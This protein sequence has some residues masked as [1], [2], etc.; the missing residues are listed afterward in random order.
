VSAAEQCRLTTNSPAAS[1]HKGAVSN[2]FAWHEIKGGVFFGR[3]PFSGDI[4]LCCNI[5]NGWGQAFSFIRMPDKRPSTGD[6]P[7]AVC[8]DTTRASNPWLQSANPTQQEGNRRSLGVSIQVAYVTWIGPLRNCMFCFEE[9]WSKRTAP[10]YL[11]PGLMAASVW[12]PPPIRT[13]VTDWMSRSNPLT[14]PVVKVWSNPNGFPMAR[15]RCP[16]R[17]RL[18]SPNCRGRRTEGGADTWRK[19][20]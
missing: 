11:F 14:T 8:A 16:T 15:H 6:K 20:G 17:N 12:M 1:C 19:Q 2:I 13:P 4:F 10:A 18:E 3:M 7:G 9:A 5:S